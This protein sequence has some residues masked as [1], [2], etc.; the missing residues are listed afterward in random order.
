LFAASASC[1]KLGIGPDELAALIGVSPDELQAWD[2]GLAPVPPRATLLMSLLAGAPD[3][4]IDAAQRDM[5]RKEA[6]SA[7]TDPTPRPVGAEAA[8][9]AELLAAVLEAVPLMARW[10]NGDGRIVQLDDAPARANQMPAEGARS[11]DIISACFDGFTGCLAEPVAKELAPAPAPVSRVDES[12]A[13]QEGSVP[14]WSRLGS[15]LTKIKV[16]ANV[17]TICA[18]CDSI[19]I[20]PSAAPIGVALFDRQMRCLQINDTLA[21][22]DGRRVGNYLGRSVW[23]LLPLRQ[24]ALQPVADRVFAA[25]AT[26]NCELSVAAPKA[27]G[28]DR[29]WLFVFFPLKASDGTVEASGV[30]VSDVTARRLRKASARD[31]EGRFGSTFEN[32]A[33]GIGYLGLDHRWQRVNQ[34]LCD[35][36]GYSKNELLT[37]SFLDV[38]HPQDLLFNLDRQS[39]LV[40][41][42]IS[43]YEIEKRYIR[44]DGMPVWVMVTVSLQRDA[45]GRPEYAIAVVQD[46]GMRKG[47]EFE[48]RESE[49][50]FRMLV[51]SAPDSMFLHDADGRFLDVNQRACESLGYSRHELLTMG[52]ADVE[53]A[54]DASRLRELFAEI[55]PGD[56][57]R[58]GGQH[59]RKD[60]STFP[61]QIHLGCYLSRGKKLMIVLAHDTTERTRLEQALR[62]SEERFHLFVD[63][64]PAWAW[65][66]DDEGTNLYVNRMYRDLFGLRVEEFVGRKDGDFWPPEI[67][68]MY[69][70]G[71]LETLARNEP[72]RFTETCATRDGREIIV[73]T[74]KFPFTD[75]SGKRY[76]GGFSLDVTERKRIENALRESEER[77]HL[78]VDKSPALTWMKT[79]DGRLIYANRMFEEVMG[80]ERTASIGKTDHE[81]WPPEVAETLRRADLTVL[82]SNAFI[83]VVEVVRTGQGEDRTFSG[84]KFPFTDT[85][86]ERYVG[87]VAL[88]ITD[89]VEL[90]RLRESEELFRRMFDQSPVGAAMLSLEHR[91]L[92]ANAE[93]LRITGYAEADLLQRDLR[94]ITHPDDIERDIA[95]AATLRRGEIETYSLEKRYIR[96]D[97][98]IAW[99]H[100]NVRLMRSSRG[101]PLYFLPIMTD[102]TDRKAFEDALFREKDRAEVT[103]HS[104][105]DGV[106]TTGA[107]GIVEYMNPVSAT[108]TGWSP[109]EA[110][111]A[112]LAAVFQIVDEEKRQPIPDLVAACLAAQ[113]SVPLPPRALMIDRFGRE[114]SIEGSL[115]PLRARDGRILG[116]VVV[117]RDV[118]Q[119]RVLERKLEYDASHDPLT[120]LPN[121]RE[122]E[123]RLTRAVSSAREKRSEHAV[124]FIDLDQFKLVNDSAGH[125]AGDELLRYVPTLLT[126]KIRERDTL[127]RLGGDEFAVLLEHC[128]LGDAERIAQRIVAA[129]EDWRFAW[130][131]RP[132]Q[133]GASVGVVAV[134]EEALDEGEVLAKAD[135]ACYAAKE[136]GRNQIHV[137]QTEGASSSSHHA[138]IKVAA[139]LKEALEQDRFRLY[140]QPI[141]A[142]AESDGGPLRF[143]I[144]V[145]LLDEFDMVVSPAR[146]I[147]AAERYGL[148]P[149]IDRWVVRNAFRQYVS[150]PHPHI[151]I[152]ITINLSGIALGREDFHDFV[153]AQFAETGMP[154]ERVCFEITE[155]AAIQNFDQARHF[156]EQIRSLGG[157]T[158]LDDF[159]SGL[160]SFKYLRFLPTDCLKIDGA[161]VQNMMENRKDFAMVAA[162]NGIGHELGLTTVA[163]FVDK[164]EIVDCL[165]AL[166]V[167]Y[168]QGYALGVPIP[169]EDALSRLAGAR[170]ADD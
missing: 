170:Q 105:G 17:R 11:P 33:V 158:A 97:G 45:D 32:A 165:R 76:V 26:L 70:R 63:S 101:E 78:F 140:S 150:R 96:N 153:L 58:I 108:M 81:L 93:L 133:V 20:P 120:G 94:T 61:A 164:D 118:T 10:Y 72:I 156:A 37:L 59:R 47:Y 113:G 160:S 134:T 90:E 147:P 24:A 145:R 142:L 27:R 42:D 44:K 6:S 136:A 54:W 127:A 139:R 1:D 162:I 155:T 80:L 2:S 14:N 22:M 169:L 166:G 111:G 141:V 85:A 74:L 36:V 23:D 144:L 12:W 163:E 68:D 129:F 110:H 95:A 98:S 3:K 106:I 39:A 57:H 18:R 49:A 135:V 71:D 41:G 25:G 46:I 122:F 100:E 19:E 88:D 146:F 99:I 28:G 126:G 89:M 161:F 131:N 8:I 112:P 75:A 152:E 29:N 107:R 62:E 104:I 48:L 124:C 149:A 16:D 82:E 50:K 65:I 30:I 154:P 21:E 86:G 55:S 102:I 159:G 5:L 34:K 38:T 119:H 125:T 157:R 31:R 123:Q 121:R 91:F 109:E 116:T 168:A 79:E 103:L 151:P 15:P 66:K 69:R 167:D 132:Y 138:Q 35:I 115:A 128:P 4:H 137:Y 84:L 73:S 77:F 43:E 40:R 117:F 53:R 130:G 148:M 51:D 87:G 92:R 60:G 9:P 64:F 52:V 13:C 67:A 83:P 7:R 56:I 114:Y 143:E